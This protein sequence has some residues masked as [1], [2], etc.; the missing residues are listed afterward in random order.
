M[1]L[2]KKPTFES[3]FKKI[4]DRNSKN[5]TCQVHFM[6]ANE[7]NTEIIKQIMKTEIVIKVITYKWQH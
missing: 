5:K 7:Q 6:V 4:P 1:L 3:N 2:A